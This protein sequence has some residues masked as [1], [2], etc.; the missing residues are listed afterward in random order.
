M[1]KRR[2]ERRNIWKTIIHQLTSIFFYPKIIENQTKL[3][4]ISMIMLEDN[5]Y[6]FRHQLTSIFS[7]QKL[8]KIIEN[9]TKLT[10]PPTDFTDITWMGLKTTTTT[11]TCDPIVRLCRSFDRMGDKNSPGRQGKHCMVSTSIYIQ[12][13]LTIFNNP[14]LPEANHLSTSNN[15]PVLTED[16]RCQL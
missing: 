12:K 1:I 11:T 16:N 7:I 15:Q 3:D 6:Q 2:M 5:Y 10:T 14:K 4:K 13:I 9:Q 8:Q